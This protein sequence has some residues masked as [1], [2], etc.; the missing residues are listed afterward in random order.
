MS[1]LNPTDVA[2]VAGLVDGEGCI[3]VYYNNVTKH[4]QL[5]VQIQMIDKNPLEMADKIVKGNWYEVV[6]NGNR[7]DVITW[8]VLNSKAEQFLQSILP[9]LKG[10][11][12]QAECA[13]K[14]NWSDFIGKTLTY[15]EREIRKVVANELKQFNRRGK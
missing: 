8:L 1:T 4:F 9:F 14:A 6:R 2:Y 13:L 3:G 7:R 10:K 12:K 11:K 15:D 5:R